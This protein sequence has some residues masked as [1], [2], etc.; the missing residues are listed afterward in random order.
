MKLQARFISGKQSQMCKEQSCS[1]LCVNH[2]PDFTRTNNVNGAL[3]AKPKDLPFCL[4][5]NKF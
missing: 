3:M 2:S 5:M 1:P 4:V